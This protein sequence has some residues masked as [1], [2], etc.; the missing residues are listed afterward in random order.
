MIGK[1]ES[2]SSRSCGG[3][4][5]IVSVSVLAVSALLGWDAAMAQQTTGVPG[6]PSATTTI[7]GDISRIRRLR[8][9]VKSTSM[10]RPRSL[11]VAAEH[12]A[13]EGGAERTADHDGRSG[14][15]DYKYVWR[16][17]PDAHH[18]PHRE[19][20]IA[21]HAVP[22][23]RPLL[24]LAGGDHHRAKPLTPLASESSPNKPPATPATTRS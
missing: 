3:A 23:D 11:G 18:G 5:R 1:R 2:G 20:G 21:L 12:R 17:H 7:D 8:S 13:T 16:R 6:S 4:L 19:N 22:F 14:L 15:R 10:P 9:V 24:T